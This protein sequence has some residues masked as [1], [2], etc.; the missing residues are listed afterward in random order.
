MF[1]VEPPWLPPLGVGV[2]VIGA[3]GVVAVVGDSVVELV[4]GVGSGLGAD[5]VVVVV[6]K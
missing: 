3:A 1:N 2:G 5:V 4:A 6:L